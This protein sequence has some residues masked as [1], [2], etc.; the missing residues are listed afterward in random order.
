MEDARRLAEAAL[1]RD[2][3]QGPL[4][5]HARRCWSGRFGLAGVG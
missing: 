1:D 3:E 4:F 5:G 2:G